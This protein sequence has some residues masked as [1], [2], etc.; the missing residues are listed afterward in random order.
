M[1]AKRTST[2]RKAFRIEVRGDEPLMHGERANHRETYSA[3]R[4]S[5]RDRQTLHRDR[6]RNR[7]RGAGAGTGTRAHRH[8]DIQRHRV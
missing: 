7:D 2:S 3:K 8:T 5:E 6:D 1:D 4:E